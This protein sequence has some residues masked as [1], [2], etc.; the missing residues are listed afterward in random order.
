M[1][2]HSIQSQNALTQCSQVHHP[3][4]QAV[5]LQ[6]HADPKRCQHPRYP[7]K[8]ASPTQHYAQIQVHSIRLGVAKLL[9]KDEKRH[10]I[11]D[12]VTLFKLLQLQ[13]QVRPILGVPLHEA[14]SKCTLSR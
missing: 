7:S 13:S 4:A 10:C 1:H 6:L 2:Q 14:E 9:A 11:L 12:P 8:P 5:D 3:L